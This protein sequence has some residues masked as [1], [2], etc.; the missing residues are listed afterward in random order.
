[1]PP[2]VR[3]LGLENK[4][5]HFVHVPLHFVGD[6]NEDVFGDKNNKTLRETLAHRRYASLAATCAAEYSQHLDSPLGEVLLRLKVSGDAFYQRFLNPY[7]DLAYSTFSIS[8]PSALGARGVYAYYSNDVL[9]YIGRCKD[10]MRKRVNQGYGKIH[11]KNCF[12]DGQR[13]NCH[14]NARIAAA[15]SDVTLWLCR[16]DNRE[17]IEAVERGLI[18]EYAPPWNIQRG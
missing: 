18:R 2:K 12:R 6:R 10:S 11:P 15:T 1:M 5:F 4:T 16:M 8:D 7:G 13:T 9:A 14:L 3:S 17:H